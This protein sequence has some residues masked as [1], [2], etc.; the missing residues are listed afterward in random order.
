MLARIAM[1]VITTRSSMRV[2]AELGVLMGGKNYNAE[3]L[4][5]AQIGQA[6]KRFFFEPVGAGVLGL[7][8]CRLLFHQLFA[9]RGRRSF[10]LESNDCERRKINNDRM[11]APLP[12][13]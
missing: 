9:L 3:N 8:F 10:A 7:R 12:F 2:N 6:Q 13:H 1:M 11:S 5:I 4:Q